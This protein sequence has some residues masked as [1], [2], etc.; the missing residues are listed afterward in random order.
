[1]PLRSATAKGGE[2]NSMR[3]LRFG[4]TGQEKP[5]MLDT[6]G[7]IRDLSGHI[8]GARNVPMDELDGH[9]DE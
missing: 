4:P 5:G 8:V 9:L 1:M 7:T 6:S 3:L 2:D